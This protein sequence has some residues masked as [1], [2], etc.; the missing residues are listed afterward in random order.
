MDRLVQYSEPLKVMR[1]QVQHG[2]EFAGSRN[3][4]LAG[5]GETDKLFI[6]KDDPGQAIAAGLQEGQY[7]LVK[8]GLV[9]TAKGYRLRL[10]E[11]KPAQVQQAR[12][13]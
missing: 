1:N 12:A 7:V 3:L 2:G 4:D 8:C 5:I 10:L 9:L 11:A 6:G 13:A